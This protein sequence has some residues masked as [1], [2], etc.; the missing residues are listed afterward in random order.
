MAVRLSVLR[1]RHTLLPRNFIFMFLVLISVRGCVY[2]LI[3]LYVTKSVHHVIRTCN[4]VNIM[5]HGF[6]QETDPSSIQIGNSLISRRRWKFGHAP[7]MCLDSE[8]EW[9]SFATWLWLQSTEIEI[10]SRVGRVPWNLGFR[11]HKP[12]QSV[13]CLR[14]SVVEGHF[15]L[16]L[17]SPLRVQ[18]SCVTYKFVIVFVSTCDISRFS[19]CVLLR[20][21]SNVQIEHYR[22]KELWRKLPKLISQLAIWCKFRD[23]IFFGHCVPSCVFF[24]F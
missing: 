14:W 24:F 21:K 16:L 8:T 18:P 22:F 2:W 15:I 3:D 17:I 23:L 6:C 13:E 5:N 10:C 20:V 19:W 1:T 11:P 4:F 7:H 9:P 12:M